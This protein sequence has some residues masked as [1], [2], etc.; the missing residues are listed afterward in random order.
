[1]N[2]RFLA[3]FIL[4]GSL[5]VAYSTRAEDMP[6]NPDPK[7]AEATKPAESKPADPV[8]PGDN[9]G[10]KE[11]KKGHAGAGTGVLKPI[12]DHAADLNLTDEQK[13][14]L[15]KIKSDLDAAEEKVKSDP[16][17]VSLQSQIK[18]AKAA[19]DKDKMK[20]LHKELKDLIEKKGGDPSAAALKDADAVLTPDQLAK[21]KEIEKEAHAAK[22]EKKAAKKGD[23]PTK[24]AD[25]APETA[26]K[27]D[28][29]APPAPADQK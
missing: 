11:K 29:T 5:T 26:A 25:K 22:G 8:K 9:A 6:A 1:M 21:L 15:D 12:F 19:N 17:V 28:P 27:T 2:V 24:P 13:T 3:T 14:K 18:E 4:I 7:P 16:E 23:D 20:T 10:G